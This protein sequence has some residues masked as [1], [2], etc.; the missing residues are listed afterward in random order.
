MDSR[1]KKVLSILILGSLLL[2]W[3]LY[4]LYVKYGAAPATAVASSDSV[5]SPPMTSPQEA[6]TGDSATHALRDL[7]ARQKE[8]EANEWGRNP[9]ADIPW[10]ARMTSPDQV[11]AIIPERTPEAPRV[12]FNGV[13]RSGDQ[14]LA[15]IDGS[16]YRVG[17]VI[18][19]NFKLIRITRHSLTLESQGWTFTYRVGEESAA[20]GRLE[21][22]SR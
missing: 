7:L 12:K 1:R 16:I 22:E 4:A 17:D 11:A 13:S 3:R 9:F 19:D 14:W 15:A 18:Q 5:Q 6:T 21:E 10:V 20:T 2:S 8:V